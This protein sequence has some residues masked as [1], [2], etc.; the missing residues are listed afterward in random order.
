MSTPSAWGSGVLGDCGRMGGAGIPGVLAD[1]WETVGVGG[2]VVRTTVILLGGGGVSLL[3][4]YHLPRCL[5]GMAMEVGPCKRL[6]RI[7]G[8]SQ[9][10]EGP[11]NCPRDPYR[12]SSHPISAA[13]LLTYRVGGGEPPW[14]ATLRSFSLHPQ[15][16]LFSGLKQTVK[17]CP[18]LG[19]FGGGPV[20][21][22]KTLASWQGKE[23]T[24]G[25]SGWG[26]SV[27]VS[28]LLGRPTI[29]LGCLG[30]D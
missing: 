20:A 13:D 8:A 22:G 1:A 29:G 27:G 6:S 9:R 5:A 4:M 24:C 2:A 14:M 23:E 26:V 15:N 7:W 28:R 10:P 21:L 3:K 12:S 19:G 17:Q 18:G 25:R 16:F 11:R 30:Q